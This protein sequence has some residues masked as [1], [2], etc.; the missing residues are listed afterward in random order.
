MSRLHWVAG[1]ILCAVLS[2]GDSSRA[3]A[4]VDWN[5]ITVATVNSEQPCP[6][7]ALDLALVHVAMHDA[8][9]T[10][11]RRFEPYHVEIRGAR[12]S[13]SAAAAAAAHGVLVKL[14][15]N[16]AQTLDNT[17]FNYLAAK[18][19]NGDPGLAVGEEVARRILPLRRLAPE[20]LP[21]PFVGGTAAGMWR[22]TDSFIGDPPAPPPF[23]P[24][25]APWLGSVDPYTLTGPAR[26]RSEP[27]PAL[28]S[29]RYRRDYDEVKALGAF[30][31]SKRSAEQ[32]DIAYF[33]SENFLSQWN[34]ALRGIATRYLHRTGDSA[35]LF[36]LANLA[37]ADAVITS[38]DSKRFYVFWRPLTAIRE[39]DKDGNP[40]TIG[41]VAWQPLINTPNYPDYTSGAN[42]VTGA[43]T[44]TLALFFGR[45]RLTFDVTSVAPLAVRKTRTYQRFSEAAQDV[46]DARVY[47]GIHF[48]FADTAARVQGS[49]VADWAFDHFLLPLDDEDNDHHL[50]HDGGQ[51]EE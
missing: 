24:M 10:I 45:D 30:S 7:C 9:Q 12:G 17:Y 44:R 40:R 13:R 38:W 39:G 6:V 47:L 26:F 16:Q 37:T 21:P 41:D 20:P 32:T 34:R 15:Q 22:P 28:M 5:E 11:D 25:A 36:A 29:E 23:A 46:V 50:P 43:M 8:V 4:V 33:Y 48:R 42:N 1:L 18:G 2:W 19:L 31:G 14:Y 27:P 35:R 3:D 51:D 49:R